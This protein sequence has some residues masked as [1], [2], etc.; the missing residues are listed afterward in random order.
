M[1]D[2]PVGIVSRNEAVASVAGKACLLV[3]VAFEPVRQACGNDLAL[4]EQ[5]DRGRYEA[6]QSGQE[7]RIMRAAKEN[8]LWR[9]RTVEHGFERAPQKIFSAW[10]SEFARFDHWRPERT[11]LLNE[12]EP[13]REFAQFEPIGIRLDGAFGAEHSDYAGSERGFRFTGDRTR[14]QAGQSF[15]RRADHA[16]YAPV[17][18]AFR[19]VKLLDVAQRAR[20]GGV[21]SED[22]ERAAFV[23]KPLDGFEREFIDHVSAAGA[24]G[25]AR[26]VSQEK[27]I[28]LW[29]RFEQRA[30]HGEATE[31]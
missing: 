24:V 19:Q 12:F 16:E 4:R 3:V 8:A 11:G 18:P 5:F 30:Q 23:E 13:R 22:D 7:Q 2:E 6:T 15:G 9:L 10:A 14:W 26:A 31:P 17:G 1:G 21:A 28:V 29:Q 27:I 20:R 25:S